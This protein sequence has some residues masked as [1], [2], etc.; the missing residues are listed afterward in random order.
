MYVTIL[1]VDRETN[2]DLYRFHLENRG[3]QSS[4]IRFIHA[5]EIRSY[6]ESTPIME[7]TLHVSIPTHWI[8]GGHKIRV[9]NVTKIITDLG[10]TK[11]DCVDREDNSVLS[12]EDAYTTTQWL[13]GNKNSSTP[14]AQ[15]KFQ[16]THGKVF[17]ASADTITFFINATNPEF[18]WKTINCKLGPLNSSQKTARLDLEFDLLLQNFIRKLNR[19]S[20]AV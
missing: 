16:V 9:L 14:D 12:N 5:F 1:F 6:Y 18:E 11:F 17:G 7:A 2:M 13:I 20:M 10:G 15:S 4:S 8:H 3:E 19:W